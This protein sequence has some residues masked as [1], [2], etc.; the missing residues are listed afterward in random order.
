M[1]DQTIDADARL[2]RLRIVLRVGAARVSDEADLGVG[3]DCRARQEAPAVPLLQ[4]VL[5]VVEVLKRFA[6]EEVIIE[7]VSKPRLEQT[8]TRPPVDAGTEA[9]AVSIEREI[10]A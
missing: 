8:S 5:D 3:Q 6:F 9:Q 1:R 2:H 7:L 10:R 4:V